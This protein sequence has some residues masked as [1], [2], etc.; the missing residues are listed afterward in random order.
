MEFETLLYEKDGNI[1]IITLNRPKFFN[2]LNDVLMRELGQLIDQIAA[3]D[4][5]K[6][7]IITGGSKAFAA[8]GDIA[9]ML[10]ADSLKAE[11]FIALC[12]QTIDKIANLPKPVIAAIA[13]LALGGGCELA[14]GCDIRIAAEG[15]TIG[16]PEINLGIMPGAGGTQRLARLVGEGWAK[17]LIFT[18]DPIDAQTALSI[19]LVTK[20]V[21]LE[22]LMDE[23]K[24]LAKKLAGKAPIA[25]RMAK[26]CINYGGSVDLPSGLL[27]EQKTWSFL[28]ST[29]DQKEGM[30]A[31]LEKR[32]PVFQGK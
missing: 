22:S 25:M 31:F 27:F 8:G 26:I 16:Q 21:P 12:H 5:V 2:A 18:G 4:E 30:K 10:D 23:A 3:D 15:T 29:A 32:K 7:V 14:M 6:A 20:V 28:F 17:Q 1:G 24:K 19:G 9:Y 11:A 13:G